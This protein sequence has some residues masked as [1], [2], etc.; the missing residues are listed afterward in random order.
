MV[1]WSAGQSEVVL[2]KRRPFA[3]MEFRGRNPA[4][5]L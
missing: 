1:G 4:A 2:R 3:L 5:D